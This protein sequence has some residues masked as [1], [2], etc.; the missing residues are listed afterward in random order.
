MTGNDA[1]RWKKSFHLLAFVVVVFVVVV[2]KE[3]GVRRPC[4]T[5]RLIDKLPHPE[6]ELREEIVRTS[7]PVEETL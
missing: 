4:Q 2:R 5:W 3:M 6:N 1:N 7:F